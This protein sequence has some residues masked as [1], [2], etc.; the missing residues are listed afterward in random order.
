MS[1]ETVEI[2]RGGSPTLR[3]T[4][5]LVLGFVTVVALSVGT[6]Q[7]CHSLGIYPPWGE[8]M[9]TAQYVLA[10]AYRVVYAVLGSYIAARLAPTRP[11]LHAMILGAIGF[12]LSVAGAAATWHM[13]DHWY[14]IAVAL[15]SLP[16]AW[17]GGALFTRTGK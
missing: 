3:S 5:A 14:A 8:P 11:M 1:V 6:D 12:V 15:T 9:E 4:G 7:L 17:A 13:G 2:R 16:C 10:L